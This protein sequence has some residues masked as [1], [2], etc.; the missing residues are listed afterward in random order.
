[1]QMRSS[2]GYVKG[3]QWIKPKQDIILPYIGLFNAVVIFWERIPLS[4]ISPKVI[5]EFKN[6][7]FLRPWHSA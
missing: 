7:G 5:Q 2:V 3:Y 1:M 4:N 6:K